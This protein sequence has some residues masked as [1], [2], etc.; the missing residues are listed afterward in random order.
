[1]PHAEAGLTALDLLRRA[2]VTSIPPS[3]GASYGDGRWD[4]ELRLVAQLVRAGVGV[5]AA[6]VDWGGW[7]TH[8][9]IGTWDQGRLHNQLTFMAAALDSFTADLAD[10]FD[11]L[12]IVVLSEFGR[13]VAQNA[14]GGTDHGRA[15]PVLVI[16]GGLRGGR[17]GGWAG[18]GTEVLDD[19]DV[20]VATD[21]RDVLAEVVARRLG[22]PAPD[23]VFPGHSPAFLGFS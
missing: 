8:E 4:R 7:D 21:R 11:R 3:N 13:R 2:D 9:G 1:A 12:T 19:G 6:A 14:S 22:N 10:L 5:E 20:P 15:G 17:Y 18:L 23:R 16:G